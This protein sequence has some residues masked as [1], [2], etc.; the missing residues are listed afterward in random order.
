MTRFICIVSLITLISLG[1]VICDSYLSVG[2]VD[3]MMT[4][5]AKDA[6]YIMK[7]IIVLVLAIGIVRLSN[8]IFNCTP[9]S[10]HLDSIASICSFLEII[11]SVYVDSC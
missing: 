7:I 8:T 10:T 3:Y 1:H 6:F 11:Y 5:V 9:E 2:I 4:M